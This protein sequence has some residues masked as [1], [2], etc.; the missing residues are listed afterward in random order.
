MHI[1]AI[2]MKVNNIV[3]FSAIYFWECAIIITYSR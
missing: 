1:C 2:Y 3:K